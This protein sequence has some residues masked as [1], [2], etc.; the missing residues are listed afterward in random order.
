MCD[1]SLHSVKSRPAR[2]GDELVTTEFANTTTRGFSAAT[3]VPRRIRAKSNLLVQRLV[4]VA[5]ART[6]CAH[7][8]CPGH[9]L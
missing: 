4:L 7:R 2:A 8:S 5:A 1:Y 6:N 3:L 9:A